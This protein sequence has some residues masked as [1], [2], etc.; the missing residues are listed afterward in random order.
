MK[1][2]ATTIYQ[3]KLA[4]LPPESG[5]ALKTKEDRREL[6]EKLVEQ[7]VNTTADVSGFNTTANESV[8]ERQNGLGMVF[9]GVDLAYFYKDLTKYEFWTTNQNTGNWNV[10]LK[11]GVETA[12]SSGRVIQIVIISF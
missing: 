3:Y 8:L 2:R 7:Y 1:L 5:P 11:T 9:D 10:A 6:F 12:T 4:F